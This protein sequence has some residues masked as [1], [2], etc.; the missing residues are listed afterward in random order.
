MPNLPDPFSGTWKLNL[1]Q[2]N[3]DP[4]HRPSEAT[5]RFDLEPEGYLMR[6]EGVCNGNAVVEHPQR[7][8]LDGKEH[9]A[10]GAP[11]VTVLSTR[12]EPNTLRTVAQTSGRLLGEGTYVVSADGQTLTATVAGIDAQQRPFQT[13]VVWHRL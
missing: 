8:I 13:T 7:F 4:N 12:P 5:M 2:S 3:F 9:P 1:Q 11:E 6:A 10:P